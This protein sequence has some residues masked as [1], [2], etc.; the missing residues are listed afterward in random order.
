MFSLLD[1]QCVNG[2]YMSVSGTSLNDCHA[3]RESTHASEYRDPDPT[4]HFEADPD[5][6]PQQND[7]KTATQ[8]KVPLWLHF[9][10]RRPCFERPRTFMAPF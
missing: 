4:V 1:L 9:E 8:H 10:H 6:D 3:G 2:E 7:P 5:P